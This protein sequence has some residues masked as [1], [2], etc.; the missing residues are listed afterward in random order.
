MTTDIEEAQR[1]AGDGYDTVRVHVSDGLIDR[2]LEDVGDGGNYGG[3]PEP[4]ASEMI[5]AS[6]DS[7]SPGAPAEL[8]G[9]ERPADG[10]GIAYRYLNPHTGKHGLTSDQVKACIIGNTLPQPVWVFYEGGRIHHVA[11]REEHLVELEILIGERIAAGLTDEELEEFD[12]ISDQGE[13]T[14]WLQENYPD[15][16]EIVTAAVEEMRGAYVLDG[17]DLVM[18][19][20]G[21]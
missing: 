5:A 3:E 21:S 4:E 20:F 12:L 17:D 13:A 16:H 9:P 1:L 18:P 10:M 15:H 7:E 19:T 6:S 2:V 14:R 8:G 11:S